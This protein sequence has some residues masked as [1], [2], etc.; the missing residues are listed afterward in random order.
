MSNK[1]IDY[2]KE[3][4]L[5]P[6]LE[7]SIMEEEQV[8]LEEN[9]KTISEVAKDLELATSVIR[10]WET[11]FPIMDP[12]KRNNRRYYSSKDQ[13]TIA[14]IKNLLYIQGYTIKA[15]QDILANGSVD[16]LGKINKPDTNKLL[17]KSTIDKLEKIRE[18]L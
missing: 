2:N 13:K 5:F 3:P 4:M 9:F 15:V 11:K 6:E 12:V 14:N 18:S 17:I 1:F 10:Y 8:V 16:D 7:K